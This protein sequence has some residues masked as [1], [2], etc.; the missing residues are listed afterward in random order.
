MI[1][2]PQEVN[3]V[4]VN[5]PLE[6]EYAF[7]QAD[8]AKLANAFIEKAAPKIIQAERLECIKFVKSLNTLVGEKLEEKRG[9]M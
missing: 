2:K 6:E 5:T 4:F 3:E 9:K 1:L 7:L 8:L